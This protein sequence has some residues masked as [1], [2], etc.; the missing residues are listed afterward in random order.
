MKHF[1]DR[2]KT[3]IKTETA[4][5]K[6]HLPNHRTS[7]QRKDSTLLKS[8]HKQ[9]HNKVRSKFKI[10]LKIKPKYTQRQ[11]QFGFRMLQFFVSD[12]VGSNT[13][14]LNTWWNIFFFRNHGI[15]FF[16]LFSIHMGVFSVVAKLSPVIS[17]FHHRFFFV[18]ICAK[19]CVSCFFFI[20]FILFQIRM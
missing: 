15:F 14:H 17:H 16:C 5:T 1:I 7:K 8:Q 4:Q 2:R 13:S 19:Q 6:N 3:M 9:I 18:R 12:F 10:N 20:F 11:S